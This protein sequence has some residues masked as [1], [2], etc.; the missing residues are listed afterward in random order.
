MSASTWSPPKN[1]QV[2]LMIFVFR[3]RHNDGTIVEFSEKGW[4]AD[5]PQESAWLTKMS[6]LCSSSPVLAPAIRVY[7]Q[8]NCQLVEFSGSMDAS[9]SIRAPSHSG[10]ELGEPLSPYQ[11]P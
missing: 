9:R 10:S 5:D 6:E 3:W 1:Q 8:E 11:K 4:K 7:L 2:V